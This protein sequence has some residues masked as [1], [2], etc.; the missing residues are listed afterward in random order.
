M[1]NLL[2]DASLSLPQGDIVDLREPIMRIRV[3]GLYLDENELFALKRVLDYATQL[4]RFFNALD[5]V[6]FASLITLPNI[7]HQDNENVLSNIVRQIDQLLDRYGKLK[8]NA[9]P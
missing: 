2:N 3:E 9:S 6:R 1:T 7:I 5:P 8:D 4:E